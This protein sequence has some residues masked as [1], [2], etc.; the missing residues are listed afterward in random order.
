MNEL[1]VVAEPG[2]LQVLTER[3]FDAPRDLVFRAFTEP[4]SSR[5]SGWDRTGTR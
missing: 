3:A 1:K 2:V 4:G 5:R